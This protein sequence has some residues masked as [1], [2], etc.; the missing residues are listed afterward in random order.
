MSLP[1]P[2][3]SLDDS[4]SVIHENTLYSYTPEAFLKLPLEQ[5]TKWKKL[6]MGEKVSG[7]ACVGTPTAFFVVGGIGGAADYSG[8]QK[9]TYADGTWATVTPSVLV[10]KERQWHGA[11][12]LKDNDAILVYAGSQDNNKTP[13]T[14]TFTIQASEPYQANAYNVPAHPAVNPILLPWSDADACMIGGDLENTAVSLF[15]P[16][17]QWR[18]SGA[19]LAQ[20]FIKDAS[21][22]QAVMMLGDDGSK[23]IY[24]FDLTKS[25]NEVHRYVLQNA[26]G[27]PVTKSLPVANSKRALS[28]DNWPEYN[29]TLA[30]TATRQNFAVA[31][32]SDGMVVF[33]GGN[34]EEPLAIFNADD[35]KWMNVTE[36]LGDPRQ[37][38]L[39]E[40]TS[41]SSS[42]TA[43][44]THSTKHSSATSSGTSTISDTSA[45]ATTEAAA[46]TPGEKNHVD[47][48][49]SNTILGITLGSILALLMLLGLILF[50]IRRRKA[51][52]N[53]TEAGHARRDSGPPFD[54]KDPVA[55]ANGT[56]PPPSPGYFRGH[57][58][59]ASNESY[60]SMAILM[61]RVGQQKGSLSRKPSHD[62]TRS[63]VSSVH[64]QL[65]STIS[66]PIPHP[67]HPTPME[68]PALHGHDEKGVAFDPTVAEP[69]QR[70]DPVDPDDPTRRS[71][72]WNRYWSGGSALQILGFG[73]G[74]RTTMGSEQSSR[75]SE[76]TQLHNNHRATQDSA[77][78]PPLTFAAPEMSRVNSGSPV[79]AEYGSKIPFRDGMAGKIERPPS[80]ASSGYSSGIPESVND[81]WDPNDA[82]KPWG[83]DRAPE[84]VYNTSFYFGTPLSPSATGPRHPPSGV[85]NQ[86]QLAM[87]STSS[88]M[89]WLNLGEQPRPRT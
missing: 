40:S 89:S 64:K 15:N 45:T 44:K 7:A 21:S 70:G 20:P 52:Q 22:I 31:Q 73:A 28:L 18:D 3:S 10:T 65:K 47:G 33:S 1:K 27:L 82:S 46:I 71:S 38:I 76:G 42:R 2:P 56:H 8:L 88:D 59:Q 68:H 13:S 66:K 54:E 50:F 57:Q 34:A 79:V 37:S 58:P 32:G 60:S 25:P 61:G 11:T 80:K 41:T 72:G 23:S 12:Y 4:C 16:A 9:Y 53:H 78:V 55:F 17:A 75:Y 77:T 48:L 81:A 19:S 39:S 49:S 5:S 84:N 14:Q 69:R 24:T 36:M 29:A 83:A 43:T 63:S 35:N 74:K 62:T 26:A 67:R 87:A 6:K 85:S 86:P 30:P 51:R